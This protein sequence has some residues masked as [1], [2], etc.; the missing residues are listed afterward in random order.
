[1]GDPPSFPAVTDD[2]IDSGWKLVDERVETLFELPGMR[3]CGAIRQY[4]DVETRE[5]L[6][7]FIAVDRAL[8]EG[9]LKPTRELVR[10]VLPP[11]LAHGSR[12]ECRHW[13]GG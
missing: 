12:Q 8:L 10:R 6:T 1:M 7:E 2:R 5:D 4:E 11:G 3:V 13:G 9:F